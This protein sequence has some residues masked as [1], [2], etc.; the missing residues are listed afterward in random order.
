MDSPYSLEIVLADV[1]KGYATQHENDM[2]A[3]YLT[4]LRSYDFENQFIKNRCITTIRV[5]DLMYL[6]G[7][8]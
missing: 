1:V 3:N 2:Y 8:Y 7:L 4:L 6:K 5:R